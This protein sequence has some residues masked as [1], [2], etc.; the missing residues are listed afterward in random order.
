MATVRPLPSSAL[1]PWL[2]GSGLLCTP[3]QPPV[4]LC[5]RYFLF[6]PLTPEKHLQASPPL[7]PPA[8]SSAPR[9]ATPVPP[10]TQPCRLS[11][12]S[13]P[14]A[15][16]TLRLPPAE[17]PSAGPRALISSVVNKLSICSVLLASVVVVL[18][19]HD[20]CCRL[21]HA[22]LVPSSL[23]FAEQGKHVGQRNHLFLP[24]PALK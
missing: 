17:H 5:H 12:C 23:V 15:A 10:V 4:W 21:R 2:W 16:H 3:V 6:S 7:P 19:A 18:P 1:F 14:C 8:D 11:G 20:L 13:T 22:D 24:R 9:P